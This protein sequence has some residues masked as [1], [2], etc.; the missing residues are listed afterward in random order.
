LKIKKED[1][2]KFWIEWQDWKKYQIYK[3]IQNKK[4]KSRK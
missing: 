2:L 3:W 4:C 1:K